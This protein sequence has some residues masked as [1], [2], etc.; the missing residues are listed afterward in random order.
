MLNN[1]ISTEVLVIGAKTPL[2]DICR[3][4]VK[5]MRAAWPDYPNNDNRFSYSNKPWINATAE[6]VDL[7][8]K[9]VGP[10]ISIDVY[11][12]NDFFNMG[13]TS[14]IW[15][16][17]HSGSRWYAKDNYRITAGNE[18]S[19][20]ETL[21]VDLQNV[22]VKGE[23]VDNLTFRLYY[24]ETVMFNTQMFTVDEV[25]AVMIHEFGHIFDTFMTLGDYVW[26][27]YYLTDGIEILLG[28]KKNV[29]NI[30]ILSEK[31][32][33]AMVDSDKDAE[34]FMNERN[35]DTAKRVVLSLLKKAPRHH[36]TQNDLIANRREE[37]LA[38]L[39]C[40]RLG[41]GRQFAQFEFK[42]AKYFNDPILSRTN[43]F[44]ETAKA[45]FAVATLPLTVLWVIGHDPL[46][47]GWTGRY[48]DSI[49][50]LTKFRRDLIAQL[51]SPGPLDRESIV[52][53]IAV[54]DDILKEYSTNVSFYDSLITFFRPSIRKQQ[55]NTKMEN[56]LESLFHNDLF[57][58]A[59]KLSKI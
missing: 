48:D 25:V 14:Q 23:L 9:K 30:D 6:F 2:V 36:L 19:I 41:M 31:S 56:D 4:Y 12:G 46:N 8:R 35:E 54:I 55:Q 16:I 58:Q 18:A 47:G 29:L 50:R 26:L 1:T 5:K 22:T 33:M 43:W 11:S 32:V 52:E 45:V 39:F 51:K 21:T 42:M 37:Q 27:N 34:A 44:V 13:V 3:N 53:D 40:S 38:D 28:K 7:I 20:K 59:F 15:F 24:T 49:Q 57:L 17:G 10:R